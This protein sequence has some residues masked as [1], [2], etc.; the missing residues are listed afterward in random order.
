MLD[1]V[2]LQN[3]PASEASSRE[4]YIYVFELRSYGYKKSGQGTAQCQEFRG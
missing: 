4:Y 3:G 2:S 1:G